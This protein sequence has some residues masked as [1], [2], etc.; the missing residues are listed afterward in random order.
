MRMLNDV[1]SIFK[2]SK[3]EFFTFEFVSENSIS[4]LYSIR[5][6]FSLFHLDSPSD[7]GDIAIKHTALKVEQW[8]CVGMLYCDNSLTIESE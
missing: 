5:I 6:L 1:N 3:C 7:K 2:T 4:G 8:E